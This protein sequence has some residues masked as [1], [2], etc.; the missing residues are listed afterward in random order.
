MMIKLRKKNYFI[1]AKTNILFS[2][3]KTIIILILYKKKTLLK[4][5]IMLLIY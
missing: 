3:S 5:K 4:F 2:L 1:Y